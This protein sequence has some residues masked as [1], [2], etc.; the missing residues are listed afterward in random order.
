MFLFIAVW[1]LFARLGTID[2]KDCSPRTS[3]N[4]SMDQY[5]SS[6]H[7]GHAIYS[8]LNFVP[9]YP[10]HFFPSLP[11]TV[12]C[13]YV[14]G[15]NQ[16]L[17]PIDVG[18]KDDRYSKKQT[19]GNYGC[20]KTERDFQTRGD[21]NSWENYCWSKTSPFSQV[22]FDVLH[23]EFA[24]IKQ[25]ASKSILLLVTTFLTFFNSAN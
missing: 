7:Y 6:Q 1:N 5:S 21:C 16:W 2:F 22:Q 4:T 18:H 15:K 19:K 13:I 20:F 10:L 17:K 14:S 3:S 23:S 25:R 12:L 24:N 11:I 8:S 9:S